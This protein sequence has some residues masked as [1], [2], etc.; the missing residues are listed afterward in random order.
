[1][2]P[3]NIPSNYLQRFEKQEEEPKI[4]QW[5]EYAIQ[6]CKDFGVVGCYK[7]IIFK[8]AKMNISFLQGKVEFC[9]EKFGEN[10]LS[11]KGRYL[12]KLFSKK[13]PWEQ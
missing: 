13:R 1:M 7:K 9:K 4:A 6:V 3:L 5:Q 10:G 11:D 2:K 12:I 8:Q